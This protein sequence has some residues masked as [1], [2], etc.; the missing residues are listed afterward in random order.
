MNRL[1]GYSEEKLKEV[2]GYITA[3]EISNQPRL[4]EETY[5][6]IKNREDELRNFLD[7]AFKYNNLRIIFTGAGSSAFVGESVVPY[8]NKKLKNKVEAIATTDIVSHPSHFLDSSTPT[9]II[10]CARS[11]NS[12]ES[13]AAIDLAK[14][15]V[16]NLY[17]VVLTCNPKGELACLAK[18]DDNDIMVLMPEDSND[19]GFA[20]TG[21]FTTMVLSSLLIFSLDELNSIE[22]HIEKI[23]KNGKN[24]LI[25]N[26]RV[27]QEISKWHFDRAVYLGSAS[28]NGLAR[29]SAL[30][31]L[32]LTSGKVSTSYD[33][34][35]GFRHGPKSIVDDKT[36]IVM[37]F[38]ND[39]YARKY[40]LDLLKEVYLQEGEK[41]L[42]A[43]SDYKDE[44]VERLCDYIL[45]V[46]NEKEEYLDDC[47][48]IF[49]YILNAQIL[50][51]YKSIESGIS[52]DNPS[53][54]GSVNRVVK[55]VIIHPYNKVETIS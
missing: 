53:P 36:L 19:Q 18:E 17:H 45:Y 44:E 35:L 3:V 10:S 21:S 42:I 22:K 41:K 2:L 49:N 40:E 4:W 54:D 1:L 25:D 23:V 6:I 15:I 39:F 28:L 43:I 11:G 48:L 29:E 20:M 55:G 37:Y 51:L 33:T 30:K 27:L 34:S 24:I 31:M 13:V 50:A 47:Y 38:S 12:P 16:D 7:R 9:L 14:K 8:L 26:V 5:E 52:P 46:N 32:E